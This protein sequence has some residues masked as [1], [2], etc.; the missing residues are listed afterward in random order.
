MGAGH[1][2]SS[3]TWRMRRATNPKYWSFVLA[4]WKTWLSISMALLEAE[5]E[6]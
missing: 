6:A 4:F 1:L 5:G 3:L 2:L